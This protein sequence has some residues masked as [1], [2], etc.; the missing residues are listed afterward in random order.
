MGEPRKCGQCRALIDPESVNSHN[1]WHD[2]LDRR[3]EELA[4]Q[5]RRLTEG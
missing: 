5:V 1:S 4:E 3:F 2:R